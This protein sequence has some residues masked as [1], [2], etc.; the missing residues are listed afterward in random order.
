MERQV[1]G[2]GG[3]TYCGG[4]LERGEALT[5]AEGFARALALKDRL[6]KNDRENI[7][8]SAV[9]DDESDYF[10]A[11]AW[12]SAL[13]REELTRR[14]AERHAKLH[15]RPRDMQV[16]I[17]LAGRRVVEEL[18][19]DSAAAARARYA[20]RMAADADAA[21]RVAGVEALKL[22]LNVEC[23]KPALEAG[24]VSIPATR[25][26]TAMAVSL[27]EAGDLRGRNDFS[28]DTLTGRSREIIKSIS[29]LFAAKT[30]K[31]PATSNGAP[32]PP[33]RD[34]ARL[35]AVQHDH[36]HEAIEV[37]S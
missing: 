13:E 8:R 4:P 29:L 26:A 11:S 33:V 37:F 23:G 19:E 9:F 24:S 16:T 15:T 22:Q 25:P 3:C 1:V 2:W 14:D 12:L 27:I 10:T 28:N 20:Q 31:Q 21:R 6:V 5:R 18:P 34:R 35:S 7:E 32:R 30:P 17:D 36:H